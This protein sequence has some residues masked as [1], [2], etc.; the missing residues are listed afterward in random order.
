MRSR[1]SEQDTES[2]YDA[3]DAV[4]RSFWD[5]EGGL[6]WGVFDDSTGTDFLKACAN[7]NEVMVQKALMDQTSRVLDLGCGNGTNS[8]WLSRTLGCGVVGVDLSGVRINNAKQDLGNQPED[9][10]AR[11]AFEKASA[12]D[13]P[14][15]DSSFTHAWSQATIYHVHEKEKAL[16]EVYRVL[17]AGGIFVFDDLTKPK[18][19]ISETARTYVYDRLIFDTNFSFESYQDALRQAGF[20]ILDAQDMSQ[21]LKTSYQ[22][23]ADITR[24]KIG[25]DAEKY[26][27]LSFAYEQMVQAVTNQELGWGL[28]LCRK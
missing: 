17:E 23:L 6:H 22:C 10:K 13:L 2:F 8:L 12:T 5:K 4:Y 24:Q 7:L 28:Y 18:P 25:E 15:E 26:G 20:E 3:E 21:H 1:F 9:I 14:F 19:D 27:T 11:V 16:Q